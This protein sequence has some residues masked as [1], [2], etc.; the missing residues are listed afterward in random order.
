MFIDFWKF[1]LR[2]QTV[3]TLL[4]IALVVGCNRLSVKDTLEGYNFK[5]VNQFN[6][7]VHFPESYQGH[8]MLVG[9]VYT[10]CPDIC[11]IITYNMRD[12]QQAFHDYDNLLLVSVSFDPARDTP[13]ILYQYAENFRL[14]QDNWQ[15][16]TGEQREVES[17]LKKLQIF[18]VKT[19]T[20]FADDN[21]PIY[22]I[23]H[24]DRVTL[25][26]GKGQIRRNYPGSELSSEEVIEYIRTLLNES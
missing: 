8:V 2:Y 1:I 21:T 6:E 24:T 18:T 13:E 19:P 16:L 5:L 9:Y 4:L 26:D 12:V 7:T 3:T 10:H 23:D 20:R 25:I 15:L 22:F 11:P 14:N 17:L